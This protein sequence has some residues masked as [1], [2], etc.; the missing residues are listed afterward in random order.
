VS[1]RPRLRNV[2]VLLVALGV[3]GCSDGRREATPLERGAIRDIVVEEDGN[4]SG[5][6]LDAQVRKDDPLDLRV[7]VRG[8]DAPA[9][10]VHLRGYDLSARVKRQPPERG[11]WAR[12]RF[13]ATRAGRFA[14]ILERPQRRQVR[15]G[16]VTVNP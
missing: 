16:Y 13:R 3:A 11:F 4:V 15:V 1:A 10:I 2:V 7:F 12:L 9:S 14:V 5:G 8:A 6:G